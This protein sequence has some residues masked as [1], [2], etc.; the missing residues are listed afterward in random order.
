[1]NQRGFVVPALLKLGLIIIPILLLG[2][3]IMKSSVTSNPNRNNIAPSV[4]GVA[5]SPPLPS[6]SPTPTYQQ[7]TNNTQ[8][9]NNS[10]PANTQSNPNSQQISITHN[11]TRTGP[12]VDYFELCTGKTIKVYENERIPYKTITGEIVY[13]T[14]GDIKCYEDQMNNLKNQALGD[15]SP[16]NYAPPIITPPVYAPPPTSY[17]TQPFIYKPPPPVYNPPSYN[18]YTPP[19]NNYL[20]P[21]NYD[22]LNPPQPCV[23]VP[24][25]FGGST[26]HFDQNGYPCAN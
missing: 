24:P 9:S 2:T 10:Q 25:G 14:R 5:V 1:M 12:I 8:E 19:S 15:Y 13:S 17:S 23:P 3:A 21:P 7:T 4:Q 18:F 22:P 26:N 6:D 20:F 11:G 16:P